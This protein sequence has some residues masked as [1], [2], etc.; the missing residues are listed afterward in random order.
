MNEKKTCSD[1]AYWHKLS[2]LTN[3]YEGGNPGRCDAPVPIWVEYLWGPRA[4]DRGM[5]SNLTAEI[6]GT[7]KDKGVE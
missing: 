3:A 5:R 7:F 1:C 2:D 4:I 6:C